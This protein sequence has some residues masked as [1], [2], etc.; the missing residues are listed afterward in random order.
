MYAVN[1]KLIKE[2]RVEKGYSFSKIADLMGFNDKAKYY[3]R[4]KGEYKFNPEELPAVAKILDI[5]IS[6]IFVLKVSKIETNKEV[7]K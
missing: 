4:E 1:L 6:K 2:K 3:R 5:P 7:T